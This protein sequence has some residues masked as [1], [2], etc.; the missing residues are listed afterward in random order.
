M[1]LMLINVSTRKF[2]RAVRLPEGDV[3]RAGRGLAYRR[4]AASRHFVAL[5]AAR[6]KE[7]M[8]ADLSGPRHHGGADRR[9]PHQRAPRAGGGARD[10]QR[11]GFKHPLGLM[12]GGNRAQCCGAGIDRRPDRA[13]PRSSG[14]AFVYHR[15]LEGA[16][17]GRSGVASGRHTRRSSA[18]RSTRPGTSWKRLSPA[19]HASSGVRLRQAWELDDAAKAEKLIRNP[20]PA[21]RAPNAPGVSKSILEGLDEILT[22]SRLG[23]PAQLRRSLACTNI[24]ENMMG[25]VRRVHPQCEALEFVFDGFCAG[26]LRP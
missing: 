20:R 15:R 24:I 19:L 4:S 23:L 9:H 2:R 12:E 14:A 17:Q 25:T 21:P 16:R 3:P 11:G 26:P 18:A 13:G 8:G 10:R 1:N 5:S 22:V 7:W 6:M